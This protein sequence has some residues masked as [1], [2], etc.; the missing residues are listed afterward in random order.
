M[1]HKHSEFVLTQGLACGSPTSALDYVLIKLREAEVASCRR[2]PDTS[3]S[4]SLRAG[5]YAGQQEVRG[6]EEEKPSLGTGEGYE[7]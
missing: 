2:V 5:Y 3:Q 6:W 1:R 4:E 7:L